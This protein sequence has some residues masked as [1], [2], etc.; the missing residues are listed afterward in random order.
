MHIQ[1]TSIEPLLTRILQAP[2]RAALR[3]LAMGVPRYQVQWVDAGATGDQVGWRIASI[4]DALTRRA[5]ELAESELGPPP[6][7]F[8]WVACGSQGRCEQTAHTDQDNALILSQSPGATARDYFLQLARRVTRDLD[9]CGLHLCTGGVM[10]CNTDWQQPVAV[11]Q[12][13]FLDWIRT[14]ALKSV[15]LA[16][17]FL[18]LRTIHGEPALLQSLRGRVVVE[19]RNST[20]FLSALAREALK[21]SPPRSPLWR[22]GLRCPAWWTS[23]ATPL[24]LKRRGILP[25]VSLARLL[26]VAHG[27]PAL[28]TRS[29]LEAAIEGGAISAVAGQELIQAWE[30]IT[31]LRVRQQARFICA[32]RPPDNLIDGN[33]LSADE[34][35]RLCHA[36]AQ[37]RFMQ[38]SSGRH[39]L[40]GLPI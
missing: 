13:Y 10:A 18:D 7:A 12:D 24:N 6:M 5:I 20:W 21:D 37:V 11:W 28:H 4:S 2:D 27:L 36:F 38:R 17:N 39:Y 25:I 15:M 23:R 16:Q 9:H 29:R 40:G 33:T 34:R 19:A 8:A 35:K 31:T 22:L 30:L 14:P 26:T 32:G 3:T 1:A